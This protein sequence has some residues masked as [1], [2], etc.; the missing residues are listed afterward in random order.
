MPPFDEDI[1]N[2]RDDVAAA[3]FAAQLGSELTFIDKQTT[4]RPNRQPPANRT[5]PNSFLRAPVNAPPAMPSQ[6]PRIDP[7]EMNNQVIPNRPIHELMIPLPNTNPTPNNNSLPPQQV[8][9][10][11]GPKQLELPM[12]INEKGKPQNAEQWFNHLDKKIDDMDVRWT[13]EIQ[14]VGKA[15]RDLTRILEDRRIIKIKS[16]QQPQGTINV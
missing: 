12:S 4:N 8:V 3:L 14:K 2:R 16:K 10:D 6:T 7:Y 1:I 13:I 9:N 15:V 5:N 11:N